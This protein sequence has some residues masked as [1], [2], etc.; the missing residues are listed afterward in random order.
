MRLVQLLHERVRYERARD[1]ELEHRLPPQFIRVTLLAIDEC[2]VL[3][4]N[5]SR[6]SIDR[7]LEI[8]RRHPSKPFVV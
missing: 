5:K 4:W 8:A 1:G 3:G 6:A 2:I 7:F